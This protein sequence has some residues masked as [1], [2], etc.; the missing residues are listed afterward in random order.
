M[1]NFPSPPSWSL[2]LYAK[3][4]AITHD[5]YDQLTQT[6]GLKITDKSFSKKPYNQ[7]YIE[8]SCE[9]LE[10]TAFIFPHHFKGGCLTKDIDNRP[11][12]CRLTPLY[13]GLAPLKIY[14]CL[15]ITR[16]IILLRSKNIDQTKQFYQ[17]FDWAPERHD[18]GPL[19]YA[20][21]SYPFLFEIYPERKLYS[22]KI[23]FLIL[24]EDLKKMRP[25]LKKFNCPILSHAPHQ[26]MARDPDG[27][28][29]QILQDKSWLKV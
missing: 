26:I 20:F 16:F 29:I 28:L 9:V 17:D 4:H 19:H 1:K 14:S 24:A 27:R 6:A 11:L 3:N 22:D 13:Y 12:Y 15:E 8:Q 23:E 21:F 18:E 5:F 7:I 25:V 10:P 2:L